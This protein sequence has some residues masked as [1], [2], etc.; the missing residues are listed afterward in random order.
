MEHQS[1]VRVERSQID[2]FVQEMEARTDG[3]VFEKWSDFHLSNIAKY[4]VEQVT[5]YVFVTDAM[6]FCFWPDNPSGQF[7]YEH[8]TRNLE[9]VLDADPE[10]FTPA[11]LA[12]V[13]EEEIREK[14]FASNQSFALVDERARL[15]REVGQRLFDSK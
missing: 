8:M 10:W 1:S 13:S 11:R 9:K 3:F 4:S 7:E 5:A 12:R 15:V 14:V 2:V 6:N